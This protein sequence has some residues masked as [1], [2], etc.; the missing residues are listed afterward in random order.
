MET[1]SQLDDGKSCTCSGT[2]SHRSNASSPISHL[3]ALY[4]QGTRADMTASAS[5]P[6]IIICRRIC[7]P[8]RPYKRCI[9]GAHFYSCMQ[10]R[11]ADNLSCDCPILDVASTL[12]PVCSSTACIQCIVHVRDGQIDRRKDGSTDQESGGQLDRQMGR[13]QTN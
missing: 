7:G 2:S 11:V 13:Q 1:Y 3:H 12:P 4:M 6:L 5:S 8:S 10:Y 9:L